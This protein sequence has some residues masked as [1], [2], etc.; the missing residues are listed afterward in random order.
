MSNVELE[1]LDFEW[2]RKTVDLSAY[3]G[4]TVCIKFEATLID[5]NLLAIDNMRIT[6]DLDHNLSVLSITAPDSAEA[7]EE[8]NITALVENAGKKNADSYTANL[9]CDEKILK[10]VECSDLKAEELE[11]IEFTVSLPV[12][13]G[14]NPQ[15]SIE[16]DYPL[17]E[18][19]EDNTSEKVAVRFLAPSYPAPR[20]LSAKVEDNKVVLTWDAPNMN[21]VVLV[22]SIDDIEAYTPFST[23]LPTTWI[24]DDNIGDWTTI[25]VDGLTTYT[26]EFTY[27][28]VGDPMAFVVYNSHMQEDNVFACHSGQQMFLSLASRPQ[29]D[30]GND[31]W[32]ISP[33]LAE[34]AQ[35]ISFYAKTISA[36]LY[37]PDTFQVL[38]SLSGKEISDFV[39]LKEYTSTGDWKEYTA[40]IPEGAKYF[41]V[42][43]ISYDKFAFLLDDFRMITAKDAVN[44]LDLTGYNVYC[45]GK[46]VNDTLVNETAYTHAL[47]TDESSTL[48][49]N[50][51]CLF[52]LGESKPS[53][54][55]KVTINPSAVEEI[56]ASDIVVIGR[57]GELI[58]K[59]AE[60]KEVI[61]ADSFGRVVY[62]DVSNGDVSIS[63]PAGIYMVKAGTAKSKV[64]VR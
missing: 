27:P 46:R 41:A 53:E 38:Y 39:L 52:N 54:T 61:V 16:I 18:A 29:D 20:N 21:D 45:N 57:S 14:E 31:D 32:L 8:F 62:H 5:Y 9:L 30:K 2:K 47:S 15:F 48:S 6:N 35:T 50:V 37:G 23:G 56:A 28:G 22:P 63:V 24:D 40:N 10:S 49:Y 4:E 25:D 58:V 36:D 55:V 33:L 17:D 44:D 7:N 59:G 51:S 43:C 1:E 64:I 13:S 12:V 26:S 42:R 34:C 19:S 11:T 3:K 60:G